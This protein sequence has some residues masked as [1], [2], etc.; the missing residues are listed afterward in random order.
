MDLLFAHYEKL[1]EDIRVELPLR[2]IWSLVPEE[3]RTEYERRKIHIRI[4]RRAPPHYVNNLT[5]EA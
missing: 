3:I 4:S 1:P 5:R 2:R